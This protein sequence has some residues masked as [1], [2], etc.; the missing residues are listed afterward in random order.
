MLSKLKKLAKRI[1]RHLQCRASV[2]N[3]AVCNARAECLQIVDDA[4]EECDAIECWN[5]TAKRIRNK[6]AAL[7]NGKTG[8]G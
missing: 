5:F 7:D 8:S 1:A 2:R 6:I 4:I 3:E